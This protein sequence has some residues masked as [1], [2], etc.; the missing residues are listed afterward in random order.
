MN[1]NNQ[2]LQEIIDF[3]LC[4]VEQKLPSWLSDD[5]K[6]RKSILNEME[7]HIWDK[8]EDLAK[9]NQITEEQIRSAIKSMGT[10][11]TIA[12]EYRKRGTPYIYISEEWF[13]WYKRVFQGLGIGFFIIFLIS[14]VRKMILDGFGWSAFDSTIGF[15]SAYVTVLLLMTGI[16]VGLS[17]EGILPSDMKDEAKKH[18]ERYYHSGISKEWQK[19]KQSMKAEWRREKEHIK[20]EVK[21]EIRHHKMNWKE[22]LPLNT[23][24]L[25]SG[26]IWGI[27][28][29]ILFIIQPFKDLNANFTPA[30]LAI[31]V[32]SGIVTVCAS[33]VKL[34]QVFAGMQRANAQRFFMILTIVVTYCQIPIARD[35]L[36]NPLALQIF[37]DSFKYGW[38]ATTVATWILWIAIIG[39]IIEMIS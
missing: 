30:F 18:K 32:M 21:R 16:F 14:V 13:P 20:D 36:A 24:E 22:R 9:G 27:I 5:T 10:P 39:S 1:S 8:A 11:E 4:K 33:F 34:A 3:Y 35:M 26:G 15:W 37:S 25:L 7:E 29:G 12:K 23:K 19:E 6:E 2:A 38:D 31:V 17:W 28:W